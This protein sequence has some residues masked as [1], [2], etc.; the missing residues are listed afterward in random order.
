[1]ISALDLQFEPETESR[2]ARTLGQLHN[3][4]LFRAPEAVRRPYSQILVVRIR[5]EEIADAVKSCIPDQ[6][7]ECLEVSG[8]Q[9][10]DDVGRPS[11]ARWISGQ[12]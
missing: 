12:D 7:I 11:K 4:R 3:G 5:I 6:P 10:G 1:M 2:D 8:L 9:S